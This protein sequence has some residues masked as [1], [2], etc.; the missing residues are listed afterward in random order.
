MSPNTPLINPG[1]NPPSQEEP[2]PCGDESIPQGHGAD[3]Q[4]LRGLRG[5]GAEP[6]ASLPSL[7]RPPS[8]SS[9]ESSSHVMG[10]CPFR[11][12]FSYKPLS[13]IFSLFFTLFYPSLSCNVYVCMYACTYVYICMCVFIHS[14]IIHS[15]IYSSIRV[16]GQLKGGQ[17]ERGCHHWAW[18]RKI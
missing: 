8:Y 17:R 10:S 5:K 11:T 7:I 16:W 14:F 15:F 3:S 2:S 6:V 4:V 1:P 9:Q 12:G 18:R 13:L